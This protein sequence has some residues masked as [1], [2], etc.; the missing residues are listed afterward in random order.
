MIFMFLFGLIG[1]IYVFNVFIWAIVTQSLDGRIFYLAFLS[2]FFL[3]PLLVIVFIL[4]SIEFGAGLVGAGSNI[5]ARMMLLH[6]KLIL[7]SITILG[8]LVTYYPLKWLA[9]HLATP[10]QIKKVITIQT[11]IMVCYWLLVFG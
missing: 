5:I 3:M 7:I 1:I 6:G 8:Q 9:S 11:L 4:L 2:S 10:S